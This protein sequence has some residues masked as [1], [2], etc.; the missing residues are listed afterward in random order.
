MF[1][2]TRQW[3]RELIAQAG[4]A[5]ASQRAPWILV[6]VGQQAGTAEDMENPSG[7]TEA[8]LRPRPAKRV[9]RSSGGRCRFSAGLASF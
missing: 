8:T 1:L 7:P 4:Q 3:D 9:S 2:L 5:E 6:S